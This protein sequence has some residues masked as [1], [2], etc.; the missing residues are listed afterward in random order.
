MADDRPARLRLRPGPPAHDHDRVD[1]GRTAL[2]R[3][4]PARRR[5]GSVDRQARRRARRRRG[6][7]RVVRRRDGPDG[8]ESD[9]RGRHR[10]SRHRIVGEQ[11]RLRPRSAL[12]RTG[13]ERVDARRCRS[14]A[15][16]STS[17]TASRWS[18]DW[19]RRSP[20]SAGRT[21]TTSSRPPPTAASPSTC[22]RT[23][24]PSSPICPASHSGRRWKAGSTCS[25][26]AR[27]S[28]PARAVS[29]APTSAR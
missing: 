9:R 24:A 11:R 25:R 12:G 5:P 3:D 17:S 7:V 22:G 29:T 19:T 16:S 14:P 23:A 8:A 15:T 26:S 18:R 13:R 10:R 21:S 27:R 20:C 6:A 4:P 2:G 28:W 1:A